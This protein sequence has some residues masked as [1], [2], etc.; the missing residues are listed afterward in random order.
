MSRHNANATRGR[1]LKRRAKRKKQRR[2]VRRR[3]MA[4]T[5]PDSE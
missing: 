3:S 5:Q 2:D 4:Q 1:R